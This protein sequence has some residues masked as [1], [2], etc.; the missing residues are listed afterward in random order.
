[1]I[2]LAIAVERCTAADRYERLACCISALYC[3]NI[4]EFRPLLGPGPNDCMMYI[5]ALYAIQCSPE[6]GSPFSCMFTGV[7]VSLVLT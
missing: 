4:Q 6:T 7:P 2:A 5:S 3:A 1:M